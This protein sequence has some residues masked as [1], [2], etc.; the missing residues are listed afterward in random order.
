LPPPS[1]Y[2]SPEASHFEAAI[3]LFFL[4]EASGLESAGELDDE[5]EEEK[6]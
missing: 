6:E 1:Y 4:S 5:D 2:I 3:N